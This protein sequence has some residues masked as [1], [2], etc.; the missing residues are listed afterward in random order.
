MTKVT[1]FQTHTTCAAQKLKTKYN[2]DI[3]LNQ[4]WSRVSRSWHQWD[5]QPIT[6]E[7]KIQKENLLSNSTMTKVTMFQ[8]VLV[9]C[10]I[11]NSV[12]VSVLTTESFGIM[13]LGR[14]GFRLWPSNRKPTEKS[15]P[16]TSLILCTPADCLRQLRLSMVLPCDSEVFFVVVWHSVKLKSH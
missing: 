1:M 3:L 16:V 4:S 7:D 11:L 13:N 2:C 5:A 15:V 12:A 6:I 8:I 14:L 10:G 9:G